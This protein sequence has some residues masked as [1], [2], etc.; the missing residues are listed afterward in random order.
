MKSYTLKKNGDTEELHLF[1]GDMTTEGCTSNS[2]SICKKMD[3]SESGGNVFA[4]KNDKDART[5]C[6]ESGRKV[7]G[8]CVSHLY[9]TYN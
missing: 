1:E 3:K 7:C 6:A 5:K 2:K 4:C 9:T 8:I